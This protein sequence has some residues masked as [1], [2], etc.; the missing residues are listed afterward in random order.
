MHNKVEVP[1]SVLMKVES[2]GRYVGGEQNQIIKE[3][4]VKKLE[5]TG[6][7]D[8]VRTVFCFPDV[9]EIGMS[10]LAMQ[11][12]YKVLNKP[13]W[14]SCERCFSPWID[15]DK[16]M[17]EKNIPLYSLETKSPISEF[18]VVAFSMGY[19]MCFTN[20]LQM[21]DLGGI[22]LMAKDRKDEDP[23]VVGGGPITCNSEPIADFFDAFFLGEG[24]EVDLEFSWLVKK[25]KD[26][27]KKDRKAL[28]KELAKIE[29]VYVPSLYTPK[30]EDGKFTGYD[31]EEGAPAKV[32]KR[33]IKDLD[34]VE[35][36]TKPL[37][38]NINVI[39]NRAYLE[40][41]R[42]CIRGCRFCQA[43]FICRPVREKDYKTLCDQGLAI[44]EN[45]GYDELGILSLSTSDYSGLAPMTDILLESFDKNHQSLSLPS[46]RI[47]NFALD[48]MEKASST[49]KSGLTF[50]PEA[51][52][53][54]LRDVINKGICEEDIMN[55]LHIAFKGGWTTVKLYFML[56]LP[57]ETM[58]DVEGI[59]NLAIKIE[60][61]YYDTMREIGMKPRKPEITVS[62]SMFIPKPFTPFQ[63]ENQNTEEE[64]KAKQ[65]HLRD[66]LRKHRSI[67][68]IWHDV[69]TSCWEGILARGDRR[70]SPVI[71]EGYRN[72][73]IFDA[74]D[75]F[76]DYD[77]WM[78]LLQ[79]YGLS[80]EMYTQGRSEDEVLPW[81]NMDL[82]VTKKFLLREKHNAYE[83][84]V[85]PNCREKCSACGANCYKAGICP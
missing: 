9:Y 28:L 41:F 1:H 40:L 14:S 26:E 77:M 59:A 55:A 6:S 2:P 16:A 18:D 69:K 32:K 64:F 51:G 70:L 29:G 3:E 75:D 30:Y 33:I 52:T 60:Q 63:W 27:G 10:N 7:C 35:Y 78:G 65:Q 4:V 42:G 81:D 66:M 73:S 24:E 62:T 39:H 21:L 17:R 25:Y 68:Y 61:L 54:R 13:E 5:E 11:I 8:Q 43:G 57:T 80:W 37:V 79:K 38:P 45:T 85:T 67:R 48:L 34:S 72:G 23:I 44:M 84:K 82:G 49:R 76:F 71:L 15:M 58:E 46:L 20:V 53:Q 36:P 31:I 19:E 56:G 74:W 83:E 47:D 50:A 12:L 22:P